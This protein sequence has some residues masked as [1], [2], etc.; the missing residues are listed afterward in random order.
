MRFS[1]IIHTD[2]GLSDTA[3]YCVGKLFVQQ[4]FLERQL[5]ALFAACDLKLALK[6]ILIYADAHGRELQ[7]HVEHR[8]IYD[9][10]SVQFPVVIVRRTAVMFL[11]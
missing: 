5:R 1:E 2:T 8:I 6:L 4:R 7:P 3:A 9:D 11:A 10:I